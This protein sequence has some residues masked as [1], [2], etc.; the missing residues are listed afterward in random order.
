MKKLLLILIP[1]IL[2]A[3]LGFGALRA[4]RQMQSVPINSVKIIRESLEKHDAE[5][6][7]KFFDADRVLENAAQ[8]ILTAQ[9]NSEVNS[10][11]YSTQDMENIYNSRKVEF[12]SSAKAALNDYVSSKKINFPENLSPTQKWLK[13]SEI[14]RCSIKNI[15]K[16]VIKDGKAHAKVEFYNSSLRFNFELEIFMEKFDKKHWRIV[17]VKNFENYLVGLNRALKKK[18]ES[19]NAPIREKISDIFVTKGYDA[20]VIDGDEYGFSKT[21]RLTVKADVKTDKP[22]A[23]IIGKIIIVDKNGSEGVTPFEI[24]MAYKPKGLQNFTVDKVLNPFVREDADAMK[25]GLRKSDLHVEITE[26]IFMDGTNLK[27]FDEFPQ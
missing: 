26:I 14:N 10:T 27:Q 21:L 4:Y 24:D 6:F 22:L 16:F 20:K 8:E 1:L 18:L 23:K 5:T 2:L 9:I 17:E 15:S 12:I 3:G 25:H 19:L 11:T 7:Y 13:D